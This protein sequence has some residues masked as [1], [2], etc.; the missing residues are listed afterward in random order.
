MKLIIKAKEVAKLV[1][2][3]ECLLK[4]EVKAIKTRVY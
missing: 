1:L 3:E 4:L 2:L